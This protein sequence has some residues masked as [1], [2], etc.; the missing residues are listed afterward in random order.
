MFSYNVFDRSL[1]FCCR[2]SCHVF[3]HT[4]ISYICMYINKENC[5]I[6]QFCS[7]VFFDFQDLKVKERTFDQTK[8][9]ISMYEALA[10]HC[11]YI[12]SNSTK[13]HSDIEKCWMCNNI[14]NHTSMKVSSS[15]L[16]ISISNKNSKGFLQ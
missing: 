15:M 8:F 9:Q 14:L 7:K 4:F 6:L 13:W 2:F 16:S 5:K 3:L 11:K 12:C 1:C 10:L